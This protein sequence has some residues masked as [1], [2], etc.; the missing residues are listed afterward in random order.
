MTSRLR[1]TTRRRPRFSLADEDR[2]T[3]LVNVAFI[4]VIILGL[5]ILVG[6]GA[7]AYWEANLRPIANVGG[8][9]LRPDLVRDR[10]N[11]LLLRLNREENQIVQARAEDEIDSAT[12]AQKINDVATRREELGFTA[13]ED[14]I[15]IIFKSQLA[16]QMGITV[17]AEDLA[18]RE[19][20]ELSGVERRHVQVIVIQPETSE[21]AVGPTF[22]QQ[23]AALERAE[24]ARAALAAGQAF[25]DVAEQYNDDDTL[26]NGGDLGF[27]TRANALETTLR[28]RLFQLAEGEVTPV[29][30]GDDA[31]YRIGRV[32]EIKPGGDDPTF[33]TEIEQRMS[34]ERYRQFLEW[35]IAAERLERQ[36]MQ[37][38]LDATPEQL[39]LAHIRL[40]NVL[41]DEDIA[42]DD[43]DQVSY[44]EI[45]YAPND[46]MTTAPELDEDDPAWGEAEA[47]AEAAADELRAIE[48]QAERL[49]RF[50]EIARE[51]SDNETTAVDGGE[52][53]AVERDIMPSDIGDLLFDQQ[54][55]DE[56]LLGPVRADAGWYLVWFHERRDPPSQ[57]LEQLRQAIQQPGPDWEALVTEYS[58]DTQSRDGGG[59]IGWWT[60]SML[61]QISE[62]LGDDLFELAVN[63][64][65]EPVGIGNSTHVFKV[66]ERDSRPIDADQAR[67]IRSSHFEEWYSDRKDQAEQD[68]TIRRADEVPDGGE[69]PGF[70]EGGDGLEDPGGDLP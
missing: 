31:D 56:T 46:D 48:D 25:E 16:A 29:L 9:E 26:P 70:D 40:E 13:E 34:I 8:V 60:Q 61:N 17:S 59:E 38:A 5:L 35:E 44:S 11:L 30:R 50:R 27:I 42:G 62:G 54:H 6:A 10:Q 19:A 32:V 43:E 47:E 23:R 28:Q 57:R 58:D 53:G 51:I 15:D 4:G 45:V 22:A 49:E 7:L 20:E 39:R 55:G 3:F 24:Q 69:D 41:P 14:L 36:V 1:P 33:R 65:H 37:E 66:L 68:G 67:F 2:Q 64:I 21:G 63:A 12:A 52:V 18:Q